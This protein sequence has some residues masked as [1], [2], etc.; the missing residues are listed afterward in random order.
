[1][2]FWYND[3]VKKKPHIYL[4]S[5]F[6]FMNRVIH[7]FSFLSLAISPYF[8][9]RPFPSSLVPL[10]QS[11]SKCE[12]ILMKMALICMKMKL[13][14]ELIFIWKISYLDSFWN[15]GTG[16]LGND[17]F[18]W[19]PLLQAGWFLLEFSSPFFQYCHYLLLLFVRQINDEG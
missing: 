5:C 4:S 18:P 6:K 12:T 16:E 19:C 7:I 11:E 8:V 1:M 10:F 13:H 17:L 15:R 2:S 9:N 14:A 3:G